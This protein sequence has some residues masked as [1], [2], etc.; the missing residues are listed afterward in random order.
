MSAAALRDLCDHMSPRAMLEV[1]AQ[2]C[3]D[4]VAWNKGKTAAVY[5]S[6]NVGLIRVALRGMVDIPGAP[7]TEAMVIRPEPVQSAADD[8]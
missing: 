7:L 2:S 3:D 1:I 4:M 5:A 8:R 6:I